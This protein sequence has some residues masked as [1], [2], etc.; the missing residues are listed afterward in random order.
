MVKYTF[1][2]ENQGPVIRQRI[3]QYLHKRKMLYNKSLSESNEQ[4]R[5]S[6]SLPPSATQTNKQY[7]LNPDQQKT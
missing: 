5:L 4:K 2:K 1:I 3:E 6:K 7:D